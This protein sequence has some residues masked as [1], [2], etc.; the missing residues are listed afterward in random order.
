MLSDFDSYTF[1]IELCRYGFSNVLIPADIITAYP[2]LYPF[3]TTLLPTYHDFSRPLPNPSPR[4][5]AIFVFND[6]RDWAP[7]LQLMIDL[8]LS[9]RG[10]VGTY[11]SLN[12]DPT[13][14]N[15]G[16]GQDSQ[17]DVYFSN[18]DLLW[19]SSYHLS[20]LGQGGFRA[21]LEGVWNQLTH[22][23]EM[24]RKVIIGKP[25]RETYDF[26]EEKL[27]MIGHGVKRVYMVGD[28]PESD[29]KGANDYR[30][31]R[32]V[33]WESILVKS[34]VYKRGKPS[35]EPKVVVD[36]VG[37]AVDWALKKKEDWSR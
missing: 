15:Q 8:L 27:M 23:A 11:S 1:L 31:P 33:E 19:A 14:P 37:E 32:G 24:E 17:P 13:L 18:A 5:S 9:S 20:R 22:G 35:W 4:I 10:V 16:Y 28:N 25:F 36:G 30:S 2:T 29:I 6:P 26:A 7:D 3:S 21:A 34:G 12:G